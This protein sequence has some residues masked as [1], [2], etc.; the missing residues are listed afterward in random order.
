VLFTGKRAGSYRY[1]AGPV[2]AL[3]HLFAIFVISWQVSYWLSGGRGFDPASIVQLLL[4]GF[5]IFAGGWIVGSFI[6]GFYLLISL[7]VFGRH[8]NEAFSAIKSADFKNFV[9]FKIEENGDLLIFPLG[10][11]RAVRK[12][13]ENTGA[14][15]PRV[16]PVNLSEENKPFL[17]EAPIRSRMPS[18]AAPVADPPEQET[19]SKISEAKA[20]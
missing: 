5:L 15:E 6:F 10:V 20:V 4:A 19:E 2:H 7:N 17:I 1:T 18:V 9:R 8:H 11:R 12:W 13:Q 3:A 14:G 16:T